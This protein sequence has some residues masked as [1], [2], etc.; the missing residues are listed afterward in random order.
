MKAKKYIDLSLKVRK[1][2]EGKNY[3]NRYMELLNAIA[4]NKYRLDLLNGL[5]SI[6][7]VETGLTVVLFSDNPFKR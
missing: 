2:Y 3:I 4:P 5:A 1:T 7:H 6:E